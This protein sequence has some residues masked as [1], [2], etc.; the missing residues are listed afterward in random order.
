[1][2]AD[3]AVGVA[4]A[5]TV[6]GFTGIETE[7]VSAELVLEVPVTVAVQADANDAGAA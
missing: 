7:L 3:I 2:L 1:M 4:D 6:I 5:V